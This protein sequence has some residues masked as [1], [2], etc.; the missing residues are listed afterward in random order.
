V[1]Y[2]VIVNVEIV[3]ERDERYLL[4]VRSAEEEYG[5]GWLTLPGG[6]LEATA[7]DQQALELTAQREL[8]EEVGLDVSLDDLHYVESHVF[9]IDTEP[10]L[11]VVMLTRNARGEPSALDPREV[12]GVVWLTA[13]EIRTHPEIPEWTRK[14]VA[15]AITYVA[16][17]NQ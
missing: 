11:D 10:V 6:K 13:D 3:V 7:P 5:A 12:A 4:I 14:S 15:Q 16:R 1:S 17:G 9:F 8:M 2:N